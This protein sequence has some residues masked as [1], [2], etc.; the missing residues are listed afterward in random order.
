M[1]HFVC[2]REGLPQ[3]KVLRGYVRISPF[4]SCHYEFP[5]IMSPFYVAVQWKIPE[6]K[7][8][9]PLFVLDCGA[10]GDC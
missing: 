4:L 1:R 8:Q 10:N 6:H 9:M 7:E 5:S 2:R 3:E